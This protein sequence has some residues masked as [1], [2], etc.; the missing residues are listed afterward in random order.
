[1]KSLSLSFF[2]KVIL[3][4]VFDISM[5]RSS[6]KLHSIE[7]FVIR[8]ENKLFAG[9]CEHFSLYNFSPEMLQAGTVKGLSFTLLQKYSRHIT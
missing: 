7:R 2:F 5:R 1:M 3:S 6:T 8:P 9:V 4:F